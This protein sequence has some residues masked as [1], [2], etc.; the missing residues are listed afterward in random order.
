[1]CFKNDCKVKDYY[2]EWPALADDMNVKNEDLHERLTSYWTLIATISG[3]LAGFSYVIANTDIEFSTQDAS[4]RR[5]WYIS[6]QIS[7]FLL[8]LLGTLLS[9]LLYGYLNI[10]GKQN[11]KWY[12]RK[13]W[14]L[15]D[16]PL[17]LTIGTVFM[18]LLSTLIAIG[19]LYSDS[20]WYL[21]FGISVVSG[22]CFFA[23]FLNIKKN[24]RNLVQESKINL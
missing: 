7:T 12:I 14:Y 3:L 6:C 20:V 21:F 13:W 4:P 8:A 23:L 24:V 16:V 22:I 15:I 11:T 2:T 9:A 5:E 19:G 1:M 17:I 10:S 18:M